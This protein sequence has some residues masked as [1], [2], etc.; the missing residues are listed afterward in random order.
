MKRLLFL[1]LFVLPACLK[2]HSF[3][4]QQTVYADLLNRYKKEMMILSSEL[5]YEEVKKEVLDLTRVRYRDVYYP[6]IEYKKRLAQ[7][8]AKTK[9][10]LRKINLDEDPEF[11][12]EVSSF[13]V[14]LK[15]IL[16]MVVTSDAYWQDQKELARFEKM[17]KLFNNSDEVVKKP[18]IQPG[19][20]VI[21]S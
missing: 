15:S 21:N 8:I 13:K 5:D 6:Y 17:G 1:F 2:D 10:I 7:D 14:E 18:G 11:Y 19:G 12:E 9:N 20:Q 4:N 16:K 3:K